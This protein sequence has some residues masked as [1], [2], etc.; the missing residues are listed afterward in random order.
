MPLGK[1]QMTETAKVFKGRRIVH[2]RLYAI[3]QPDEMA[4][5]LL[6]LLLNPTPRQLH[7]YTKDH[8]IDSEQ[9][10]ITER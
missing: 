3:V 10:E 5:T 2:V 7:T 9:M 8:A 6:N 1:G 4:P